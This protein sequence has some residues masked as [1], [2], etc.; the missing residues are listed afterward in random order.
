MTGCQLQNVKYFP[1]P[2]QGN[3]QRAVGV[4]ARAPGTACRR[5]G[6]DK[7]WLGVELGI[8]TMLHASFRNIAN[9]A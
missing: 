1:Q 7:H 9:H 6:G 5:C 4:E 3:S 2:R 8:R